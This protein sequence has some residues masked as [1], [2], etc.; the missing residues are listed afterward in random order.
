MADPHSLP[1]LADLLHDVPKLVEEVLQNGHRELLTR[2]DAR[3]G[4]FEDL[5]RFR[6]ARSEMRL[7][8][9]LDSGDIPHVIRM[10]GSTDKLQRQRSSAQSNE[11]DLGMDP[12]DSHDL[13]RL[14]HAR[15]AEAYES[16]AKI[17]EEEQESD[18]KNLTRWQRCQS[19]ARRVVNSNSSNAF[20]AFVVLSN[21][22]YLGVQL[23]YHAQVRN[24]AHYAYVTFLTIHVSYAILFTAEVCLRLVA[25]GVVNYLWAAEWHWNWLDVFVVSSSWIELLIDLMTPGTSSRGT[26]SN[27]R[28]MRLIR[29]GRLF[30]VVRIMKV[31][32]L[33]RS[34]RTLVQSLVGT[35]KSLAWAMVLL[36]LI[37]YIFSIL[38]TDAALDFIIETK[39]QVEP[40][41]SEQVQHLSEVTLYFGSLYRSFI[42]MF[43]VIS[44]GL[45]WNSPGDALY[46]LPD[47]GP[48][49]WVQLFHLYIAFCS[50]AVLN[51]M[52]GV[53]CNSAIKAAESDHEM[54]VQTLVQTRQELRDLVSHLF[55]KIDSRG[56][57]HITYTEF[58]QFFEDEAVKAFFESLQIGAVD[59]WTL[60]VSLDMD[61]DHTVSVE[62]FTERCMQLHGPA[63][64]ADLFALR[65]TTVKLSQQVQQLQEAQ[66]Q[67][68]RIALRTPS[69]SEATEKDSAPFRV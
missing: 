16:K 17:K 32:R 28:L 5:L 56:E 11:S 48:Y 26:N 50:F 64:S 24:P 68:S 59:A 53:F 1:A 43:R 2:L 23:E 44:D 54:V 41:T 18:A 36:S 29:V 62:E 21:S 22:V 9:E 14:T 6:L 55:T 67:N 39:E 37:M 51:V 47:M 33:F 4:D 27:F 69:K 19:W 66:K 12:L 13:A 49:L 65:Q 15:V 61:G 25:E 45:T 60:F 34:L 46:K 35:L 57:G 42:T 8:S 3:L 10:T 31:V 52:T 63:R 30:R 20:F 58:E 38:F 7:S 40:M